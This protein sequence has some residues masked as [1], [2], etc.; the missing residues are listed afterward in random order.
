MR[1]HTVLKSLLR[2]PR[3]ALPAVIL[4]GL[5]VGGFTWMMAL[6]RSLMLRSFPV[7]QPNRLV[8]LWNGM[9]SVPD[10]HGTPST[11]DLQLMRGFQKVFQGVAA[12]EPTN[13]NLGSEVPAR[14]HLDRVTNNYFEVLGVKP[15]L[16]RDFT[17]A[18]DE[19][20][21]PPTLILSH[22]LWRNRFGAD[23]GLVGHTITVDGA[24]AQVIGILP[25]KFHTPNGTEL[26]RPFQ[27][28]AAQRDNHGPH[29]LR[30]FARLQDGATLT[31]ASAAMNQVADR[32]RVL[33]SKAAPK[34][35]LDQLRY[36][37]T[38]LIDDNLGQG[39]RVLRI[40]RWASGLVLLLAV[41]N[42]ISLLLA[43]G[44][45]RRN[46]MAVRS[47]LGAQPADLRRQLLAEGGLLG[48]VGAAVGISLAYLGLGLTG[49]A[50]A[51]SYPDL[52]RTSLALD[53]PSLLAAAILGPLLGAACA[54]IA[55]PG[56]QVSNLLR[57][58][59][60]TP[61]L[62]NRGHLQ[63]LLVG[64]QLVVSAILLMGAMSL[65]YGLARLLS[66]DPGFTTKRVWSFEIQPGK[67]MPL[68]TRAQLAWAL[69]A[70]LAALSGVQ[71]AG[72]SNGLPMSGFRSDL[73]TTLPD[74]RKIDPEARAMTPGLV[75][76]LGLRLLRGRTFESRD[77]ANSEPV[78]LV[79]RGL[80]VQA[81]GT[82]EAVGKH[83]SFQGQTFTIVG[84][85]ADFR[86]FGS[87]QPAPP[88]FYVPLAQADIVWNQDLSV[89]FRSVGPPPSEQQ[90]QALL[91]EIAPGLALYRYLPM[92][93][94]LKSQLG[95][96]RMAL[97]FI[98]AFAGLALLLAAGGVFGIMATSVAARRSEFGVRVALGATPLAI[99]GQILRETL[100]LAIVA[101]LAGVL[102]G[103]LLERLIG[104]VLGTWPNPPIL[105]NGM[106]LGTLVGVALVAALLPALRA[107]RVP[108]GEALKD[109]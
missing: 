76:A 32:I 50:L 17:Q 81:F 53:G 108:P 67:Q 43:R 62:A 14:V 2:E 106:A 11:G 103:G 44:L 5:G 88:L 105:L 107:A 92:E 60:R 73:N 36:G 77:V 16:G 1:L 41:Y 71:A 61:N 3:T 104:V 91:R 20:G 74:G 99:L 30:V 33:F 7:F 58:G 29:Y 10:I 101:G 68:A 34:D 49:P 22:D 85:L 87:A 51:W 9:A 13:A 82:D 38:P 79:T 52:A 64:A 19:A 84:V 75:E 4:L 24:S 80:A 90:L 18:D 102:L 55:Q 37:A 28:T 109:I 31:Q 6:Q 72:A 23:P 35:L 48:L 69:T 47:A 54:L 12:W 78:M 97:A 100:R 98:E 27:W 83:L 46:E 15:A 70:R 42:A 40:L 95:P 8:S 89:A 86:E 21:S 45:G 93:D 94:L 39:L 59:G 57:T 25:D 65:H 66:T 96:Q 26:F 63:W 56:E